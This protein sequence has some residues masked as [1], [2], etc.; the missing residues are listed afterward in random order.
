MST[1]RLAHLDDA[2]LL[3][4]LAHLAAQDRATTASLLAHI[5]EVDA[6]RLYLPAAY[7]SMFAYC[8]GELRLSED[9][10]YKRIQ[11]ARAARACPRLFED[12]AAG[13]LHLAAVCLL[14]PHLTAANADELVAAA[15]HRRKAEIEAWLAGRF[16]PVAAAGAGSPALPARV[17]AVGPSSRADQLAPGQVDANTLAL[18][19]PGS[20]NELAPGQVDAPPPARFIVQLPIGEATHAKL[21][22]AQHLLAHAVPSGDLAEV[23]DRALDA[24]LATLEKRKF[25]ATTEPRLARAAH[26]VR[27]R[28]IPAAVRRAVWARDAGRCTFTSTEGRRCASRRALEFD[29]VVPFARGG[30][31]TVAGLR[32]RCRAHNQFEAERT[33]GEAFMR[34]KREGARRAQGETMAVHDREV[35]SALRGLGCRAEEARRGAVHAAAM[36]AGRIEDRLREALRFVGRSAP[37]ARRGA[38]ASAP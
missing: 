18:P 2:T 27:S 19:T 31:A 38:L 36:G 22:A 3:R 30:E 34:G 35:E 8:V 21:R 14:A 28:T 26:A 1:Y 11:A 9:A 33:F 12:V 16:P 29:H 25:A 13:R 10:A 7:S 32:L 37:R 24:L 15:T 23:L 20:A 5:A 4:D 6:R 17:I